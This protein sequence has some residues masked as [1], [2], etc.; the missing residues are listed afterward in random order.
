MNKTLVTLLLAGAAA[1][2]QEARSLTL[3]QAVELALRQHPEVALARLEE[4]K[5]RDGVAEARAPFVPRLSAGSGLAYSSGFPLSIEGSAPSIVQVQGSQ[6]LF[7]RAQSYRVKEAREMAA[8]TEISTG[9]RADEIAWRVAVTYLDWERAVRAATAAVRQVETLERVQG[10]VGER[11]QAGRDLPL[12]L[13]RARVETARSR[14]RRQEIE[15]QAALLEA[16]LRADLGL[17]EER[18][19]PVENRAP[20]PPPA[21]EQAAVEAA[22]AASK[23]I[24]RLEAVVRARGYQVEAEKS[25][26]YP[27]ADLVAQYALLGRYNNYD[28]FFRTFERH[29]G[30]IG[31]SLQLPLF[32]RGQI[33]PRVARAR[34]EAEEAQLRL[35]AARQSVDLEARRLFRAAAQAGAAR[36]LSRLELDLARESLSVALARFDEGRV[37]LRDVEQARAGEAARWE[38][39]YDAQT[40]ADKAG[41]TL[42]RHTGGLHAALR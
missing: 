33:A 18:L 35:R 4:Q 38:S 39:F 23:E 42:L 26:R 10:L 29:N 21:S 12:E 41:L 27:R 15:N 7:N 9:A 31:V 34:A 6:F 1:P 28:D 30:Q 25:E 22:L 40:A 37:A 32:A 36:E 3:A 13:T 14:A 8:S 16:A 24:Q 2:A 17:G 20:A 5:A 19:R 11:V